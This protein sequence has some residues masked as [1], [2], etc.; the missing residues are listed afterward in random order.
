MLGKKTLTLKKAVYLPIHEVERMSESEKKEYFD[1]LQK[2]CKRPGKKYSQ[3][4]TATQRFI[5]KH[6]KRLRSFPLEIVGSKSMPQ[7]G[8]LVMCNH[9]NVHDMII[10][11]E[12]MEK[13][14]K[15]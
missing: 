1:L 3:E 9:S 15:P 14:N 5:G 2:Y 13:I 7:G 6:G 4:I 12:V 8:C 10:M 11:A